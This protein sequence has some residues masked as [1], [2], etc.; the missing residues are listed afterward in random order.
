[1][2]ISGVVFDVITVIGFILGMLLALTAFWMFIQSKHEESK[3]AAMMS[4]AFSMLAI[5]CLLI[6]TVLSGYD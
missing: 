2:H 6:K 4:L 1:M 5:V 3:S